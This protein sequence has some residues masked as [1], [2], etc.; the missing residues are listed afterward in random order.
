MIFLPFAVISSQVS[1]ECQ[2]PEDGNKSNGSPARRAC[3]GT[4]AALRLCLCTADSGAMVSPVDARRCMPSRPPEKRSRSPS[5]PSNANVKR[6]RG[7]PRKIPDG[8]SRMFLLVA[9]RRGLARRRKRMQARAV[10][11]AISPIAKRA[12]RKH[13]PTISIAKFARSRGTPSPTEENS[14]Q[15]R[16][17]FSHANSPGFHAP[18]CPSTSS[19]AMTWSFSSW[20]ALDPS[21]E[22]HCRL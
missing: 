4:N 3:P 14:E 10:T 21:Q 22:S 15:S 16:G 2:N 18:A 11:C 8:R 6:S 17:G 7:R 19:S 20:M 5:S 9:R 12:Q 1:C 13:S